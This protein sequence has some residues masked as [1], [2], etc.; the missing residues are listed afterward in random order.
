MADRPIAFV[1]YSHHDREH[2]E[3]LKV[4]LKPFERDGLL[5]VWD[6][7]VIRAGSKWKEEIRSALSSAH[8]AILLVTQDFLSSDFVANDELPILLDA[9]Q[10]KG[11]RILAVLIK[12]CRFDRTA[13]KDF[14][15]VNS[16]DRPLISLGE[17]EQEQIWIAVTHAIEEAVQNPT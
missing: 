6:D 11:T 10:Q 9:A 1:S 17:T 16:I 2:L 13:L 12:P 5:S 4:F 7:T 15:F 8:I 14:Q 3:R